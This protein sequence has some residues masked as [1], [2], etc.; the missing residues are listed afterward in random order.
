[1]KIGPISG[2]LLVKLGLGVLLLGGIGMV[3][4]TIKSKASAAAGA[5]ANAI[6]PASPDN[7][8]NTSVNGGVGAVMPADAPGRNADGSWTLGGYLYDIFH[9]VEAYHVAH[10]TDPTQ[11]Q[12][13]DPYDA[14]FNRY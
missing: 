5:A 12:I 8:V 9:P 14:H 13:N 2:D 3:I 4:W 11:T 6:N 1:M 10:V 7:V